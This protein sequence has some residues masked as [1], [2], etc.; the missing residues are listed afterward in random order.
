[1]EKKEFRAEVIS[2]LQRYYGKHK[3]IP[4]AATIFKSFNKTKFYEVFP[5][6]LAQACEA[7]G[8][9][10]PEERLKQTQKARQAA[11]GKRLAEAIKQGSPWEDLKQSYKREDEER[12]YRKQ[13]SEELAK[14]VRKLATDPNE[15]ISGPV[16]TPWKRC[17]RESLN[18]VTELLSAFG[19]SGNLTKLRAATFPMEL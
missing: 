16:L 2:F 6:G 1:M 3:K 13:R 7:A 17:C 19:D 9:P 10:V 15:E 11:K 5:Q 18:V 4:S 8:I 14:Q 12:R